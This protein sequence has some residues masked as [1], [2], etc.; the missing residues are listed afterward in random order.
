MLIDNI[1][2]SAL[3]SLH[4]IPSPQE[5]LRLHSQCAW[6][7]GNLTNHHNVSL[8][9]SQILQ[10]RAFW[11]HPDELR[12][13][14]RTVSAFKS[15]V[16]IAGARADNSILPLERRI[17]AILKGLS[18]P[19]PLWKQLLPLA[20]LLLAFEP[21][22]SPAAFGAD[23]QLVEYAFL[24]ALNDAA[25]AQQ[26]ELQ[27][28]PLVAET[29]VLAANYVYPLL[30]AH[31][32]SRFPLVRLLPLG[33]AAA[34]GS[35]QGFEQAWFLARVERDIQG[36]PSQTIAWPSQ[37]PSFTAL[38]YKLESPLITSI[39]ALSRLLATCIEEAL[40]PS[41]IFTALEEVSR[42]T[43]SLMI[44]WRQCRLS[45]VD[46]QDEVSHLQPETRN[47]SISTL[48]KLLHI[49]LVFNI[50]ILQAIVSRMVRDTRSFR[51]TEITSFAI[52]V[53][54]NLRNL[55][56][57]AIRFGITNSRH[58]TFVY[59][60][61][62]DILATDPAQAESFLSAI[63][64]AEPRSI[65]LLPLDRSAE[66]YFLSTAEH[67]VLALQPQASILES[68]ILP[69]IHALITK[70]VPPSPQLRQLFETAHSL[71]LALITTSKG[72]TLCA[73]DID[74]YIDTVIQTFPS[75]LS[76][77]QFSLVFAT[78]FLVSTQSGSALSRISSIR[79]QGLGVHDDIRVQFGPGWTDLLL[80]LLLSGSMAPSVTLLPPDLPD[81]NSSNQSP[82]LP[83]TVQSV[84]IS[85]LINA[86][87][88]IPLTG[89]RC[90]GVEY[91]LLRIVECMKL[92][93]DPRIK[94]QLQ[95]DLWMML[96]SGRL[97]IERA[98]RCV[99]WWID[100]GDQEAVQ[101]V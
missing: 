97:G 50:T 29:I 52:Q 47:G 69:C 78:L 43:K 4:S 22:N 26:S 30:S 49:T 51:A 58:Y 34:L 66:H 60:A 91:W 13:C 101:S 35:E 38:Q 46:E 27:A 53:L 82:S 62:L 59:L 45:L 56:F 67:L 31:L 28:E 79:E 5:T 98:E 72:P 70:D 16:S 23:V 92:I 96:S 94:Q 33:L 24:D 68:H 63:A 54:H 86:I 93:P 21:G 14:V 75:H 84:Y 77:R 87:Q 10:S 90:Y 81:F 12:T 32:R 100:E 36:E 55:H 41:V 1:L 2:A 39:G 6:L 18:S 95:G 19:V 9:T 64:P 42:Y 65:P 7:L 85:S 17:R 37:S 11:S 73:G 3:R 40:D 48:W 89:L 44:Q 80:E 71:Q 76:A 8:L 57:L 61:C 20:G 83:K 99:R 15:A 88:F 25:D 74:R